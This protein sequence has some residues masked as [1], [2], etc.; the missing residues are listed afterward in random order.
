MTNFRCISQE[1]FELL[2]FL[3][4]I[5]AF[6]LWH[7]VARKKRSQTRTANINRIK[8]S[9]TE[10]S[11]YTYLGEEDPV[12]RPHRYERCSETGRKKRVYLDEYDD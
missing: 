2:Y 8:N 9:Q 4:F 7:L 12:H 1:D 11:H 6:V 5:L 3:I 10:K